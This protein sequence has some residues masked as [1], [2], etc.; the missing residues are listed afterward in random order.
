MS[1][2][3][4]L[5]KV[6]QLV[7]L[8]ASAALG[9]ALDEFLETRKVDPR[10]EWQVRVFDEEAH[11]PP[12]EILADGPGVLTL[13]I[14]DWR[15]C[16]SCGRGCHQFRPN[17]PLLLIGADPKSPDLPPQAA[18]GL[19]QFISPKASADELKRAF[20]Q[21]VN[22]ARQAHPANGKET[23]AEA[24]PAPSLPETKAL[25]EDAAVQRKLRAIAASLH[26]PAQDVDDLF[27]EAWIHLWKL[28]RQ[29]PGQKLSWYLQSCQSH[30]RDILKAGRSL[31]S[32]GH[33]AGRVELSPGPEEEDGGDGTLALL[34]SAPD[35]VVSEVCARDLLS[36]LTPA[37]RPRERRILEL[38]L[39][40][41]ST[42]EIAEDLG[43]DQALVAR[44]LHRIVQVAM[45]FLGG[46]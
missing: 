19:V 37:L 15:R 45:R 14:L 36:L 31:D 9:D 25:W 6:V 30:L 46:A 27:Q 26:P 40:E 11:A 42:R 28:E 44:T 4:S 8:C 16:L 22:R 23:A 35:D 12:S 1:P 34:P 24:G 13:L 10:V 7:I 21:L 3:P 5:K 41:Y 32:P 17:L 39:D 43:T 20:L 18:S 38:R 29:H 33:R 2:K